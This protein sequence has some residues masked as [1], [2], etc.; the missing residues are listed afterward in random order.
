MFALGVEAMRERVTVLTV[1]HAMNPD[2]A[3][4]AAHVLRSARR[5]EVAHAALRLTWPEGP[6]KAN[7]QAAARTARYQ[8]LAAAAAE[9]GSRHVLTAH[10]A[11]D[12]AE[13][14]LMRLARGAGAPGL[15]GIRARREIG[16]GVMLVRPFLAWPRAW[17]SAAASD[18]GLETVADPANE[19]FDHDRARARAF[20]NEQTYL[21]A[22]RLA[23]SAGHLAEAEDALEWLAALAFSSRARVD[24]AEWT[25]DFSGLPAEI[26]RRLF[27]RIL[28]EFGG[29]MPGG[30]AAAAALDA[31]RRGRKTNI[32]GVAATGGV[33]WRFRAE[34]PRRR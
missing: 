3:D 18:A 1:D 30:A 16:G 23:A 31:L 9:H 29:N 24:G 34:T 7:R 10:H 27:L 20:L 14:L 25:A 22:G 4:W 15:S 32:A 12:Q 8:A 2:S 19:N 17:F 13:T 11:E 5:A 6:P 33:L 21:E 26:Q 28:G